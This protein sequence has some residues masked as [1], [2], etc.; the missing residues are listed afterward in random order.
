[1]LKNH[2]T[3]T[4][5]NI[6]ELSSSSHEYCPQN[7]ETLKPNPIFVIQKLK[8]FKTSK[9]ISKPFHVTKTKVIL[10]KKLFK[11]LKILK[12]EVKL[13]KNPENTNFKSTKELWLDK[14]IHMLH[15]EDSS[16]ENKLKDCM[17]KFYSSCQ[18][19]KAPRS[20]LNCYFNNI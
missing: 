13:Q 1:M 7:Q 11:I 10:R 20:F 3:N 15:I 14:N 12:P 4:H 17:A 8:H 18:L 16:L 2:K 9:S 6:S 5:T 19:L